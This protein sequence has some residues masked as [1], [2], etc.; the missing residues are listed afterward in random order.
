MIE[1]SSKTGSSELRSGQ[2]THSS[3][4]FPLDGWCE[5]SILHKADAPHAYRAGPIAWFASLAA[6]LFGAA[7]VASCTGEMP[8]VSHDDP[9]SGDGTGGTAGSSGSAG[10][11]ATAN[12]G[13]G[14]ND[15]SGSGDSGNESN[16]CENDSDCGA[17][18]VCNAEGECVDGCRIDE[19]L[20]EHGDVNPSNSCLVCAATS[21]D[22]W[23]ANKG[24]A[25]DAFNGAV[26]ND[27]AECGAPPTISTGCGHTCAITTKGAAVCWGHN[28][29]GQLGDG[30]TKDA[31]APVQVSG[32]DS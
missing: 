22:D 15:G 11:G 9:D 26:C 13:A 18:K 23:T 28:N 32:L 1:T 8:R 29:S 6:L 5:L 12:G 2:S 10:A 30:T 19:V 24:A 17:G 3:Q 21:S 20:Y 27:L 7:I 4:T 25:C 16:G 31:S 14:N